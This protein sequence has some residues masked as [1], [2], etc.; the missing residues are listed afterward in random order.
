M[1]TAEARSVLVDPMAYADGRLE[2]A[3]A[4]LRRDAPVSWVEAEEFL[5]FHALTKHEDILEVERRP[6]LFQARPRYKLYRRRDEERFTAARSLVSMDPPEHTEYRAVAAPWF[7]PR[8]LRNFE[9]TVRARALVAVD[10][11]AR[12][13]TAYDFVSEIAML[14]PLDVICSMVGIPEADRGLILRLTLENFGSE[15]PDFRPLTTTDDRAAVMD[16]A[17][18]FLKVIEDRKAAPTDDITSLLVHAKVKDEPLPLQDLIGYLV[19]ISTA[20]HDT[21]AATIAGGL[22]ALV[23]HPD[24]LR[25]LQT[26]P[27]LIPTAVEEMIRWVTPVKSFMRVATKDTEIGGQTIAE[28]EAVLLLYASANRDDDVFGDPDR[29]DVGRTPNRHLAFGH[30]THFCLGARLARLEARMFF[31]ELIP[32]LRHAELAGEPELIQTLFVGGHKRLPVHL[33]VA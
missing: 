17:H 32:R 6:D 1:T 20:G 8:N 21:T 26:E 11:M 7:H 30:G 33:D 18:Y 27:G 4:V 24:Q 28:G 23:E 12:R 9:E 13:D 22:R 14:Y 2:Q 19:I 5:P 25:R 29:F 15:D 10:S 3:C 16:F 31:S